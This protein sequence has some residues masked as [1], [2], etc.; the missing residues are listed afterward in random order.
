MAGKAISCD[1][2]RSQSQRAR[3][4][5]IERAP[6]ARAAPKAPLSGAARSFASIGLWDKQR[7]SHLELVEKIYGCHAVRGKRAGRRRMLGEKRAPRARAAPEAPLSSVI[8][9]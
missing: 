7:S 5:D 9:S 3:D 6:R 2:L 4:P 1:A 8:R